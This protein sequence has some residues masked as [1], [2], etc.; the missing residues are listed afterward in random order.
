MDGVFI[1]N[2][3]FHPAAEA[4]TKCAECGADL[5][6]ECDTNAF[7]R[8]EKGAFCIR[9]SQ[10]RAL[11]GIDWKTGYLKKLKRNL[12][13]AC[14]FFVLAIV[15]LIV[16]CKVSS[17][18]AMIAAAIGV[19]VFWFLCGFIQTWKHEKDEF[20]V[21]HLIWGNKGVDEDESTL[22]FIAKIIFYV[23]AAPIMLI[24]N[25]I[26]Y[27]GTK[28]MKKRDIQEYEK[29]TSALNDTNKKKF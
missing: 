13:F 2:C 11:N 14:I 10:K 22:R 29:I 4:V 23:L 28:G 3:S 27:F 24:R 21:K 19:C 18:G 17:D 8:T 6:S 7:Y 15:C 20:S 25:I 1:M 9:C 5:C 26:E 12:V 16:A